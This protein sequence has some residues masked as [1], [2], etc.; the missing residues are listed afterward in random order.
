MVV[1]VGTSGAGK[2]TLRR[3]LVESG[4][5]PGVVL[6]LDDLRRAA[7]RDDLYRGRPARALQ[8]YSLHAVRRAAR[9]ADALATF[10]VGYLADA[11]HLRRKERCEH[12]LR[13]ADTGLASTAVLLP[14]AT[15]EELLRRNAGRPEDEQVPEDVLGRQH[16]RR[17]L[18]TVD[19]LREEGFTLVLTTPSHSPT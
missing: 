7:R 18:L 4:L 17:S 2:T 3:C 9:R 6:S 5:P 14:A 1:L 15:L 19:L 12:V 11:M 13:A 10:G 16:H 8:D